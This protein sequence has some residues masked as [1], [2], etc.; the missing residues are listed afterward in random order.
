MIRVCLHC[1]AQ[2]RVPARHLASAGRCGSCQSPLAP[3]ASPLEVDQA[4]FE[5]IL[6][7]SPVPVLV[8]FW[9]SWCGPCKMAV[10]EVVKVAE[11]LAGRALVLKVNTEDEPALAARY[12]VRSIPYFA[13]F[14]QGELVAQQ[15]GLVGFQQLEQL[16]LGSA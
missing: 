5:E 1:N 13:V 8:D 11:H 4:H 7:V 9:A 12:A 2:N 16:V 14:R 10:P 15:A 6:A 3:L